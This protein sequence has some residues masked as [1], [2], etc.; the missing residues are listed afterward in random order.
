MVAA[1]LSRQKVPSFMGI[2]RVPIF[3]NLVA[4]ASSMDIN[5]AQL[6]K[7]HMEAN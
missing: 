1:D 3:R 6:D 7:Q 2:I 4:E 5:L